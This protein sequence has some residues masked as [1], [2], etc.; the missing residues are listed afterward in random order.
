MI[1]RLG[2]KKSVNL[3]GCYDEKFDGCDYTTCVGS[4]C[5]GWFGPL[6][7]FFDLRILIA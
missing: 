6:N 5:H 7:H 1:L 3:G 4:T 2:F